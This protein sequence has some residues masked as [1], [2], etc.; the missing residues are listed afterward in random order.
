LYRWIATVLGFHK[1]L[2][3]QDATTTSPLQSL[4]D[5]AKIN[6]SPFDD[7]SLVQ[8][9][10]KILLH[11]L[12]KS[13]PQATG[14]FWPHGYVLPTERENLKYHLDTKNQNTLWIAKRR[15]GY[16]SHGNQLLTSSDVMEFKESEDGTLIQKVVESAMLL[17]GRKFSVRV[18]VVY[19]ALEEGEV[20]LM[21][22]GL[23]KLASEPASSSSLDPRVHMT[24]SGR[25]TNMEQRDLRSL[26]QTLGEPAYTNL[27]ERIH[28]L[29]WTLLME[30][31]KPIQPSVSL[32]SL[33]L[34]KILGLDFVVD[35]DVQPWLLEVNRFPGLEPRDESDQFVKS[36]VI[37]QAWRQAASRK[38]L[39]KH[40]LEDWLRM[41]PSTSESRLEAL[42]KL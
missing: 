26:K 18:Y 2:S 38:G 33:G 16:G 41:L 40:P 4:L 34:P 22:N 36:H 15:S 35:Q 27:W 29:T 42:R 13:S 25:E 11:K 24:N 31:Y 39:K 5:L 14:L 37:L 8:L 6:L 28:S 12:L 7:P 32:E 10:D 21:D 9:D 3:T 1:S 17:D 19:F 23:V 20:F 30:I